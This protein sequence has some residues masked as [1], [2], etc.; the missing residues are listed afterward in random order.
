M[1][2]LFQLKSMIACA[3]AAFA[4]QA[5]AV[6]AAPVDEIARDFKP[7]AGVVVTTEGQEVILDLDAASG[8]SP[9]DICSVMSPGRQIV[10]PVTQKVLGTLEEVKAVLKVVRL[11]PGFSFARPLSGA[12]ALKPGEPVRTYTGLPALFWDYS[13]DGKPLFQQLQSALPDLKWQDY[14][15]SQR[16]RPA[17]PAP[18]SAAPGTL[19]FILTRDAVE[20]RDP[21]FTLLKSYRRA[22]ATPGAGALVP[23]A[24]AA[25][26][27]A[28]KTDAGPASATAVRPVYSKT[29]T[30]ANLPDVALMADFIRHDNRL[31]MASTNGTRIEVLDAAAAP[32]A[33]VAEAQ[34]PRPGN[35]LALKWWQP[36]V[37]GSLHL[38][39]TAWVDGA[40]SSSIWLLDKDT[41]T[42]ASL[43]IPRILGSFDI[44][45]DGRPETLL[46][47]EYDADMFFGQRI[48]EVTRINGELRFT[49]PKI[50]LPRSFTVTGSAITDLTGDGKPEAVY[51]RNE[52]LFVYSGN[53]QMYKSTKE[54]GGSVSVLTY[55]SGAS[56]KNMEPATA[57]FEVSPICADVDRAGTAEILVPASD[58][59]LLGSAVP[60][61]GGIKRSWLAVV[62]YVNGRFESGTIGEKLDQ[63]LQGL[64]IHGQ[65]VLMVATEAGD[66]TGEGAK[67]HLLAFELAR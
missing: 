8:A 5:S 24:P 54:M 4:L 42:P 22:A 12:G 47:Q 43:Q 64:T 50:E 60:S 38:A 55:N 41:L 40:V 19:T 9:G 16:S 6:G 7:V 34:L 21:E 44:D 27:A 35:V 15:N 66:L 17:S 14:E 59:T 52:V 61:V 39:V 65:R 51:V 36:A 1:K 33:R 67:S 30:L 53:R 10:H 49:A 58:R 11:K 13:G 48:K 20:V 46:A 57:V 32:V 23:A 63:P 18:S 29:E 26:A 37:G 2:S 28:P 56:S 25:V 3:A 31:L 62:R 45:C